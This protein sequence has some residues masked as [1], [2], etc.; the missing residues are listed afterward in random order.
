MKKVL[1]IAAMA[2]SVAGCGTGG[3]YPIG[4]YGSYIYGANGNDKLW[5][6]HHTDPGYCLSRDYAAC[7]A[8]VLGGY[9]MPYQ[10][11][12]RPYASGGGYV[13]VVN[14]VKINT[15]R[16]GGVWYKNCG[17]DPAVPINQ[18]CYSNRVAYPVGHGPSQD[19]GGFA[20]R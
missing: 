7:K 5:Y 10:G 14:G 20:Q 6:D 17:N 8:A 4:S 15:W 9:R 16:R 19:S 11:Y 1:L 13:V 3:Y 2:A 12:G 18:P